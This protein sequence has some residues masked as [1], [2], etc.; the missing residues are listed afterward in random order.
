[1]EVGGIQA[2]GSASSSN[3]LKQW[4]QGERLLVKVVQTTSEGV[5]T[6]QVKGQDVSALLDTSAKVG[7]Q[8][9]VKVG[10]FSEGSLMLVRQPSVER[11]GE[12]QLATPQFKQVTER[13][14]PI[15]QEI[16]ALLKA[17][18]TEKPGIFAA[19]L[20]NLQGTPFDGLIT[21]LRKSSLKWE[22][23]SEENGAEVLLQCLRKLGLDYEQRIQQLSKLDPQAKEIEKNSLKETF[24]STLLQALQN[25]EGLDDHDSQETVTKLLQ[26]LTGQ[27]L[28]LKTGALDNAY[29]LLHLPIFKQEELIPVQIAIESARK[30]GKMDE[31]HCRVGIQMETQQLGQVGIDA[32]FYGIQYPA[33]AQLIFIHELLLSPPCLKNKHHPEYSG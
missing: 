33:N 15:N 11:Q 19:L 10:N 31:Q 28:W 6:I 4:Q 9:W 30:G 24:K 2:P 8:F 27:Q 29:L 32:F 7:D 12:I 1:M 23:L 25:L 3:L 26:R 5:G 16:I 22:G 13:G 17:F 21:N 18:P 14:L 20:T